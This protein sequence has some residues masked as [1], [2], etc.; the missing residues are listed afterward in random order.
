MPFW[1][2]SGKNP[3]GDGHVRHSM[4]ELATYFP[5]GEPLTAE[6]Q[7]PLEI[8]APL[9][10]N[11]VFGAVWALHETLIADIAGKT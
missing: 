2:L 8:C 11:D 4:V 5:A 7:Y 1:T 9:G 10:H 3:A 6:L